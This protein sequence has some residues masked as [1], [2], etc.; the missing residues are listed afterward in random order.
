MFGNGASR[1]I[2]LVCAGIDFRKA[3]QVTTSKE[4]LFVA[5][6]GKGVPQILMKILPRVIAV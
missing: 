1:V 6:K 4:R 2:D 5:R 3:S